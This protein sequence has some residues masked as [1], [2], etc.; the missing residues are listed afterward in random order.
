MST[1]VAP[2]NVSR[3]PKR[4]AARRRP[5]GSSSGAAVSSS[6]LPSTTAPLAIRVKSTKAP[7]SSR[8]NHAKLSSSS[9]RSPSTSSPSILA[10]FSTSSKRSR[11]HLEAAVASHYDIIHRVGV[12]SVGTVYQVMDRTS[13]P[14]SS[15]SSSS[16]LS[17]S[18]PSPRSS[19]SSLLL[20]GQQQRLHALKVIRKSDLKDALSQL[21]IR[22]ETAALKKLRHRHIVKFHHAHEDDHFIYVATEYCSKGDLTNLL[23]RTSYGLAEADALRIMRQVLDALDYLHSRGVSHRDVKL[24]NVLVKSDGSIR[25]AD[26]GLVHWRLPC[27]KND[28]ENNNSTNGGGM[29]GCTCA[30]CSSSTRFCGTLSYA[31]PEVVMRGGGGAQYVPKL[32]DMW[33]CGVT[34]YALLTRQLPFGQAGLLAA[35]NEEMGKIKRK[36]VEGGV[37]SILHAIVHNVLDGEALS[38]VSVGCRA[39]LKGLL[40]I[41]PRKR[42]SAARAREFCDDILSSP[43]LRR[44]EEGVESHHRR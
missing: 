42:M 35:C 5:H 26:L 23:R 41:D 37:S 43:S 4:S 2:R 25:L 8:V 33:A 20:N 9:S 7:S 17:V 6:A 31:A 40:V 28:S 15:T 44:P 34:L 22:R 19:S 14:S 12:G 16:S 38:H 29:I 27:Q 24:Q 36:D 32:V 30:E 13:S 18:P 1:E 10:A 39:L 11:P 21:S 3:L